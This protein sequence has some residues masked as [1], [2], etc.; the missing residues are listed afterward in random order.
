MSSRPLQGIF[1]EKDRERGKNGNFLIVSKIGVPGLLFLA[2]V[3]ESWD[4]KIQ[5]KS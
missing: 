3:V 4:E 1:E 2:D 5:A